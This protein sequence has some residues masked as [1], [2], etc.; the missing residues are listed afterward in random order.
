MKISDKD[1]LDFLETLE[2]SICD[3]NYQNDWDI[4]CSTHGTRSSFQVS[5][6]NESLTLREAIDNAIMAM[7]EREK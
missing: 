2:E 6:Y 5:Y 3:S 1:R 7:R 4:S